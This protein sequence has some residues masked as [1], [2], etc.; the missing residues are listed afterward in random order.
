V[1]LTTGFVMWLVA[2]AAATAVGLAAVAAIG[3]D[4]FGAGQDPLTQSQVDDLLASQTQPPTTSSPPPSTS[5]SAPTTTTTTL[6]PSP[7]A[8]PKATSTQGGQVVARCTPT[9]L[10]EILSTSP[11]QGYQ[12]SREDQLSDHPHVTFTNGSREVE[13]RLRCVNGVPNPEIK[14]DE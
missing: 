13:I 1:R 4:I 5:S 14:Y 8:E 12:L 10:V 11:A 7:A 2:A 3:T 9:G 6:P